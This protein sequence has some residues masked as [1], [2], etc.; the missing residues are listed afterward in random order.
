MPTRCRRR[1]TCRSGRLG[2][3][4]EVVG[5]VTRLVFGCDGCRDVEN[6]W[7]GIVDARLEESTHCKLCSTHGKHAS[8]VCKSSFLWGWRWSV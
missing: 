3:G 2:G 5:E 6:G 4:G 1:N 7:G 8:Y